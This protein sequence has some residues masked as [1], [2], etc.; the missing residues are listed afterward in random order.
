MAESITLDFVYGQKSYQATVQTVQRQQETQYEVIAIDPE[1]KELLNGFVLFRLETGLVST[2]D[3][4]ETGEA[5]PLRQAIAAAL[6]TY[7]LTNSG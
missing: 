2:G 7:L 1:L 4:V 6:E 5:A 3:A